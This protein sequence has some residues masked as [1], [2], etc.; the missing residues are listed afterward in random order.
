MVTRLKRR[1]GTHESGR[2]APR[3]VARATRCCPARPA[4]G[5]KPAAAAADPGYGVVVPCCSAADIHPAP[6]AADA[7]ST[8]V[9]NPDRDTVTGSGL[10]H[11]PDPPTVRSTGASAH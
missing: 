10:W 7:D 4:S 9:S 5:G 6:G 3:P 8:P 1:D 11:G 2:R